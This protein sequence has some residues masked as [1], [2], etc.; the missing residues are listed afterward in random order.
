M[1]A[2]GEIAG[3][4]GGGVYGHNALEETFLG[5]CIFSGRTAGRALAR[6][7]A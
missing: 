1:F 7:L 5:G 4:G 3:V 2:A 6:V